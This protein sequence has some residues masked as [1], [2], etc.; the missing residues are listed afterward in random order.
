MNLKH[1]SCIFVTVKLTLVSV[2]TGLRLVL[3]PSKDLY[4]GPR[5]DSVWGRGET[6]MAECTD[7]PRSSQASIHAPL[8]HD[9]GPH[10]LALENEKSMDEWFLII[11]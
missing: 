9:N 11:A 10:V 4:E 1:K 6:E 2:L 5:P 7:G 3:D 8:L